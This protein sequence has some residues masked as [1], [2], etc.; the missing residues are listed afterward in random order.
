MST[1]KEERKSPLGA[2]SNLPLF[3]LLW[4][5]V[6]F[7]FKLTFLTEIGWEDLFLSWHSLWRCHWDPGHLLLE[8]N[9]KAIVRTKS[10]QTLFPCFNPSVLSFYFSFFSYF[11][12]PFLLVKP[13]KKK[14]QPFKTFRPWVTSVCFYLLILELYHFIKC[15]IQ[16]ES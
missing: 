16:L 7:F 10:S 11:L 3:L 5:L 6:F 8:R 4:K 12:V 1:S 15:K 14:W 9:D 13:V 2:V